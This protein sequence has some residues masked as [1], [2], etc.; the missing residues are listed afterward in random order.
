MSGWGLPVQENDRIKKKKQDFYK[1]EECQILNDS[2]RGA[3]KCNV[4]KHYSPHLLL[5]LHLVSCRYSIEGFALVHPLSNNV[6]LNGEKH[7]SL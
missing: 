7:R 6:E 2:F 1:I 3:P 5:D 4:S